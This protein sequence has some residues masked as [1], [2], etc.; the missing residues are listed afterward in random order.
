MNICQLKRW[1]IEYNPQ[2]Y[3][4]YY[5]LHKFRPRFQ[6]ISANSGRYRPVSV[7]FSRFQPISAR[8]GLFSLISAGTG[9]NWCVSACVGTRVNQC[10]RGASPCHHES[11]AG[12]APILP[13]RCFRDH[14]WLALT[15]LWV[16]LPRGWQV[17][18]WFAHEGNPQGQGISWHFWLAVLS[19]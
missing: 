12:A 13:H 3:F 11:G 17:V 9:S 18:T 19:F 16:L 8:I 14:Q 6:P 5:F 15:G 4:Y 1:Y 2:V 10:V 7:N